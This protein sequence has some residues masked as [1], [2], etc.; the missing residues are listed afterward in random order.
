MMG[1]QR[2]PFQRVSGTLTTSTSII[3]CLSSHNIWGVRHL[4]DLVPY[5]VNDF[6]WDNLADQF[7]RTDGPV[8]RPRESKDALSATQRFTKFKPT[9][10]HRL[11]LTDTPRSY[12][13]ATT[14]VPTRRSTKDEPPLTTRTAQQVSRTLHHYDTGWSR[15]LG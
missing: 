11:D 13:E 9:A 14:Q 4:S 2:S 6:A 3:S 10:T 5:V 1:V 12:V 8:I 15:R 7:D